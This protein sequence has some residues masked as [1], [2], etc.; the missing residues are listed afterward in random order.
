MSLP[1]AVEGEARVAGSWCPGTDHLC[2][3]FPQDPCLS[4][5]LL[6]KLPAPGALP[7]CRPEAERRCDVCATHLNQLTREALRLLQV[8][9]SREDPDTFHGDPGLVPSSPGA[10]TGP[11]DVPVPAGLSGRQ[12]GRTGLDKRK[13]LAWP[14]GPSVQVSVAPAGLGGALSTVT[15][16]AQQCLEG[17]WSVSRVNSFLPPSCLV[18]PLGRVGCRPPGTT[19]QG[20]GQLG[21][22]WVPSW[23][24]LSTSQHG[25]RSLGSVASLES[26]GHAHGGRP[27]QVC[28]QSH[29]GQGP[30]VSLGVLHR[31]APVCMAGGGV[32]HSCF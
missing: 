22:T 29:S 14:S 2:P 25:P 19:R 23:G 20:S 17:M 24:F 4:A 7:A 15:I 13:G 18:S 26:K 11:R 16:Q 6:D 10:V 1:L 32:G 12:P 31:T 30:P 5:L 9:A 28:R 8:P 27:S 21:Q 3:L